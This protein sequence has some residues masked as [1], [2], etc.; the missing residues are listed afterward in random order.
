MEKIAINFFKFLKNP[1]EKFNKTLSLKQKWNILFSILLLDFILVTIASGI[2][3]IIDTYLFELKSEPIEDL[4]S[5]KPAYLILILAA[6]IVPLIEEFIFRLFLNYDR[7][8]VF[9]FIDAFTNNK[10]KIFWDKHFKKIFYIAALLFGLMHLSN[11]SN[12]NTLFYILAPFIILPQLIGGVT[13]GYIRLKLGFFWG[14]LMH[15]LYNLIVFSVLLLFLNTTLLTKKN[16]PD[17]ILEINK[18]ELGLNKPIELEIYK[19]ETTIDSII[20]NNTTVKEV[21]NL[22]NLT[23][24]VLLKKTKRINIRFINKTD[25]NTPESII[26]TELK[27]HFK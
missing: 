25:L 23:D 6:L 17:Y 10:A 15:G 20:G 26:S 13:L 24:T 19:T 22:L 4:F 21:A 5:N 2:T 3:S 18:L 1:Q 12:T 8:F 14:V 11:F 27:K 7:N 16:T 9:Q